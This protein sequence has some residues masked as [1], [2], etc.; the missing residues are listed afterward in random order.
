MIEEGTKEFE[1]FLTLVQCDIRN[2]SQDGSVEHTTILKTIKTFEKVK[3]ELSEEAKEVIIHRMEH[4]FDILIKKPDNTLRI[5][6]PKW[7]TEKGAARPNYY[8]NS[9]LQ[10]LEYDPA[11][12][13]MRNKSVIDRMMERANA[14]LD[15]LFDPADTAVKEEDRRGMVMGHVQSGKTANY[16]MLINKAADA[17]FKFIIVLTGT[18]EMFRQQT[19]VRLTEAF[20]GEREDKKVGDNRVGVGKYREKESFSEKKPWSMTSS[21]SDFGVMYG[22]FVKPRG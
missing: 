8:T 6:R 19:Q 3:G 21:K 16:S 1:G 4:I 11:T 17:G 5:K 14:I 2:E 22:E 10:Y 9:Y 12:L 20:I 15:N 13:K 18:I 7:W